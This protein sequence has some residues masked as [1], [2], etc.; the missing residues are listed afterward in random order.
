[1]KSRNHINILPAIVLLLTAGQACKKG[2]DNIPLL[3]DTRVSFVN[4]SPLLQN[5]LKVFN[6]Y[7]YIFINDKAP[8]TLKPPVFSI[9][10]NQYPFP[11]PAGSQQRNA[12]QY[13]A[14]PAGQYSFWFTDTT[15]AIVALQNTALSAGSFHSLYLTDS[16]GSYSVVQVADDPMAPNDGK[17]RVRF[18]N[19][20]YD[21]LINVKL[22]DKD[23]KPVQGNLPRKIG[24]RS[25]T[26]YVELDTAK[27]VDGLF[28]LRFYDNSNDQT[29]VDVASLKAEPGRAYDVIFNGYLYSKLVKYDK[30]RKDTNGNVVEAVAILASFRS[31]IRNIR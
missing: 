9:F 24:Y 31:M 21:A 20:S 1:M 16:A 28:F 29:T 4:V 12:V 22:M 10:N 17:V 14:I 30:P 19:L 3:P 5:E 27:A 15:R 7:S 26:P 25:V 23:G 13:S 6:R 8:D 18:A 2:Q 11:V